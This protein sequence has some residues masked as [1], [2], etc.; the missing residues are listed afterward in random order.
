MGDTPKETEDQWQRMDKEKEHKKEEEEEKE[1]AAK[2]KR[3]T[4]RKEAGRTET[5][6]RT[7]VGRLASKATPI[8][9]KKGPVHAKRCINVLCAE[10]GAWEWDSC[11]PLNTTSEG[12][13]G[14]S[15]RAAARCWGAR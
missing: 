13:T 12:L 4:R 3:M 10:S 7:G 8:G 11:L 5:K 9:R 6:A 2:S 15:Q 14:T 1:K